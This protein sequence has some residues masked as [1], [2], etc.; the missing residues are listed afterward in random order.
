MEATMPTLVV[1]PHL[2]CI[3]T[4]H[5]LREE[6]E[7]LCHKKQVL[8]DH[9][10]PWAN[11][12]L[13]LSQDL[14]TTVKQLNQTFDSVIAATEG[15]NS[16]KLVKIAQNVAA[17]SEGVLP[18]FATAVEQLQANM[19]TSMSLWRDESQ[20]CVG[21]LLEQGPLTV[22]LMQFCNIL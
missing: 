18:S 4:S 19:K 6:I 12:A 16:Q 13:K 14:D 3:H 7:E 1:A 9:L 5:A 22:I 15:L 11:E 21:G 20:D 2:A 8:N 10:K 17:H